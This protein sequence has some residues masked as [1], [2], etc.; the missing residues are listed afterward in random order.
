[1]RKSPFWFDCDGRDTCQQQY[2]FAQPMK[3]DAKEVA[4]YVHQSIAQAA[5][6]IWQTLTYHLDRDSKFIY[7][8]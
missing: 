4:A 1:M 3:G 6:E 5:D 2:Y 8:N 7:F